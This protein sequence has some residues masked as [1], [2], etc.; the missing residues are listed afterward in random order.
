DPLSDRSVNLRE[1]RRSYDRSKKLPQRLV[2]EMARVSS[3]A[4][5]EWVEARKENKF[6][7][8]RPWLEKIISLTQEQAKC[9]GY[10]K[11]PYDALLEDY[12]PGLTTEQLDKLFPTLKERLSVLVSKITSSKRQPDLSIL[13]KTCPVASQQAFCRQMAEAMGFDFKKGRL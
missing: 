3:Q 5:V 10:E 4:Q 1:W 13:K 8:F 12:E 7:R 9:Y 11:H 6:E 2:E